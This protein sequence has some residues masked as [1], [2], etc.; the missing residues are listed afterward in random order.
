[1][2]YP[3][4]LFFLYQIENVFQHEAVSLPVYHT[5]KRN[6]GRFKDA[7]CL[8]EYICFPPGSCARACGAR[9][10]EY[11][12]VEQAQSACS[13]PAYSIARRGAMRTLAGRG[14]APVQARH[15][16]WT[17]WRSHAHARRERV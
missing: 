3:V 13:T 14:W 7:E 6:T 9:F 2:P 1:M 8:S 12:G 10:I 17:R 5:G 16:D 15:P 4:I 11:A